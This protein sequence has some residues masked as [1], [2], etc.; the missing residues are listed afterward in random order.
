MGTRA[1]DMRST[2]PRQSSTK[3]RREKVSRGGRYKLDAN[4]STSEESAHPK[5]V[6]AHRRVVRASG[7]VWSKG[8]KNS[9]RG[10]KRTKVRIL[11]SL[12]LKWGS[13][14][15]TPS[16]AM[17]RYAKIPRPNHSYLIPSHISDVFCS[18]ISEATFIQRNL[19]K[20]ERSEGFAQTI[21]MGVEESTQSYSFVIL[22]VNIE[23]WKYLRRL[24]K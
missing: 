24:T 4:P 6:T 11:K 23:S 9:T 21:Q 16:V 12:N 17:S 22:C 7:S 2:S 15:R 3:K 14:T 13:V 10:Q 20:T 19:A 1:N 8:K 5:A 18:H